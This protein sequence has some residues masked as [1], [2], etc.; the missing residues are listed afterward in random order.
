MQQALH[1]F[2]E[3]ND[4][5]LLDLLNSDNLDRYGWSQIGYGDQNGSSLAVSPGGELWASV[6]R[7]LVE[8][9]GPSRSCCKG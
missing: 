6:P 8:P 5:S 2:D 7:V 3:T 9:Y 4:F 1:L